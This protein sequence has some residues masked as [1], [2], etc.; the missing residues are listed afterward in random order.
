MPRIVL[1]SRSLL[2]LF[3][4]LMLLFPMACAQDDTAPASDDMA[5]TDSTAETPGATVAADLPPRASEARPSPNASVGQT[6]G[7]NEVTITYGRPGVKGRQV[8]GGLEQYGNVWRAGANEATVIHFAEDVTIEGQ[9]LAAGAYAFFAIPGESE[10]TLIFNSE[11][12][13]WGAFDHDPDKDALRVTVT[14]E[15]GPMEEWLSYSFEEVSDT[16]ATA[17][18]AWDTVRVPFTIALQ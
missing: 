10:W 2:P 14:S 16:S 7:T 9:P 18:L 1:L 15:S 3:V 4:V 13:Q 5:E 12:N 8:F 17:V 11:P 6:I